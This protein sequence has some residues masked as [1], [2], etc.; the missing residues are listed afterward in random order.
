MF[1]RY[2]QNNKMILLKEPAEPASF[3]EASARAKCELFGNRLG[4]LQEIRKSGSEYVFLRWAHILITRICHLKFC[5]SN[6][7]NFWKL[8]LIYLIRF[9]KQLH[10]WTR[11]VWEMVG[12]DGDT[13]GN[14]FLC[15]FWVIRTYFEGLEFWMIKDIFVCNVTHF[16]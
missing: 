11:M 9:A 7:R 3:G 5:F 13:V 10:L 4:N 8:Y 2:A 15:E 16:S 14:L 6:K 12:Y 1:L